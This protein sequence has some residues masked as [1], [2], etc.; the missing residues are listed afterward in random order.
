MPGI[1]WTRIVINLFKLLP[2]N[3]GHERL[4]WQKAGG[5]KIRYSQEKW[6]SL[7]HRR[8]VNVLVPL[9]LHCIPGGQE[10]ATASLQTA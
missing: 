6:L 9:G 1:N 7:T 5:I 4:T 3:D 8:R 10:Q 2:M